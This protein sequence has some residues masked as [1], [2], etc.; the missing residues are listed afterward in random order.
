[1][2]ELKEKKTFR[3]ENFINFAKNTIKFHI[4]KNYDYLKICISKILGPKSKVVTNI[5]CSFQIIINS[6]K[7]N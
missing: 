7:K 4:L 6:Q 5:S 2:M 3:T 1:M